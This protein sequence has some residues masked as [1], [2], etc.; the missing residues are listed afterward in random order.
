MRTCWAEEDEG[1]AGPA[2]EKEE[3]A[4]LDRGERVGRTGLSCWVGFLVLGCV[5]LGLLSFFLLFLSF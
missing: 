5:A 4:E 3:Q 1:R 2:E